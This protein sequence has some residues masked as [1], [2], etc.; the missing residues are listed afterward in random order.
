MADIALSAF[1]VFFT[2]CPS[3]LSFQQAMEQARGAN[4]AR[5]LFGVQSIPG[6]NHIRHTLDPVE[7]HHLF[8]VYDELYQAFEKTG[9]QQAMR[10]IHDTELIALDATLVFHFPV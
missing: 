1:V 2:Q 3:F 8:S 7:P 10:A 9:S 4:N 5:S 6:D